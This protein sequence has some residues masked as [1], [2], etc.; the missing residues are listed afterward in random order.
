MKKIVR[1]TENDLVRL[2]KRVLDEQAM[3]LYTNQGGNVWNT[4]K[5]A[6]EG[7]GTDENGVK[8][9]CAMVTTPEIY[10]QVLALANKEG[11]K[12]VM[13]YIMTDFSSV[14]DT[15]VQTMRNINKSSDW[16]KEGYSKDVDTQTTKFCSSNL[17]KFN[18]NEM[19][20][21]GRGVRIDRAV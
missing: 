7:F 20:S 15:P 11:H 19:G 21:F 4:L 1:L 10:K 9:A 2:V 6:I 18:R 16:D 3:P 12:T 14:I 13:D 5:K 8:R 17:G